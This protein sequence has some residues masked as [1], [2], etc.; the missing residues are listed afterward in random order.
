M[1]PYEVPEGEIIAEGKTKRVIRI[2]AGEVVLEAKDDI[3]AGDGAKH[4]V[5]TG[6]AEVAT[7]T[8]CNVFRFLAACGV[9]VAFERQ[10][11][12]RAFLAPRC[13]MVLDEVVVRR[14]AHGSALKREPYL[15][16]G[17]VFP[18]LRVEHYLKTS[19][20]RWKEHALPKDDP[21][22]RI[23]REG[24]IRLWRPDLPIAG[25]EPFLTLPGE[26]GDKI[27]VVLELGVDMH[28]VAR[29]EETAKRA[30]LLLERAW[31]MLGRR[32]VDFKVEFGRTADGTLL[33]ADVIDNDSWRVVEDG[34]YIDKQHYRDGGDLNEVTRRYRH[35]AALT[36]R[37]LPLPQ[38]TVV[39]WRGSDKDDLAPFLKAFEG[40]QGVHVEQVTCSAHKEP[41][42]AY[43]RLAE[44]GQKH[45]DA[46]V[47]AYV[48]RSNG[49]GPTL[50]ANTALPVITVPASGKEM[51]E[52]VWSSL[53]MPSD[54][55]VS[56]VMEPANAVKAALG[57]LAQRDPRIWAHLRHQ[58]EKRLA[59][60]LVLAD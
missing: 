54:V 28:E 36:E 52:D 26:A 34:Q 45:P 55:P 10:V 43:A 31:A 1:I 25:T 49:L 24:D 38:S 29:M 21:Y 19:G 4:D 60:T 35:V 51:P 39:L 32:L 16:K 59:N 17:H 13:T 42:R 2:R 27:P 53:R 5:I 3:T 15:H 47:I 11:G 18:K 33:L 46:V 9:P 37:F 12:E 14:E 23:G 56:T 40:V 50:A 30:F 22:M 8:T 58:L 57:I 41:A 48:G 20:K 6:K 7:A 44:V